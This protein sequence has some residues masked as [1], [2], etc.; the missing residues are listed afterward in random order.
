MYGIYLQL[1]GNF[2]ISIDDNDCCFPASSCSLIHFRHGN[3]I[4]HIL[5]GSNTPL[6][7]LGLLFDSRLL[8]KKFQLGSE[9]LSQLL[10]PPNLP[11]VNIATPDMKKV[12]YELLSLDFSTYGSRL[13]AEAKALELIAAYLQRVEHFSSQAAINGTPQSSVQRLH[14]AKYLLEQQYRTPP[15]L[16]RL[17]RQ[18]GL[19][20][21]K[22]AEEFKQLFGKSVYEYVIF[23]RMEKAKDRLKKCRHGQLGLI[24]EQIGYS[25]QGSFSKAFKQYTGYSP[26]EYINLHTIKKLPTLQ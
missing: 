8:Q 14:L 4:E 10:A 19:N 16:D 22:L 15:S 25:Q 1:S 9:E 20:R 7:Y 12:S 11:A 24:A 23:L 18:V 21:R 5:N 3:R 17:G 2:S 6:T 26:S 13:S